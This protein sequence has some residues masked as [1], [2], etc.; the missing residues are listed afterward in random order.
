[1]AGGG[2][3]VVVS[4]KTGKKAGLQ[5]IAGAPNKVDAAN[6]FLRGVELVHPKPTAEDPNPRPYLARNGTKLVP[7]GTTKKEYEQVKAQEQYLRE[8]GLLPPW[9]KK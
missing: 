8:Q 6:N 1:M 7:Y 9:E 2:Q 5:P 3:G 4:D